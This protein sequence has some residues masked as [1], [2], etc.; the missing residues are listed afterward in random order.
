MSLTRGTQLGIY[1]VTAKS[2]EDGVGEVWRATTR[3]GAAARGTPSRRIGDD[4]PG[5]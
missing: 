5:S 1:E 3:G 2:G 4:Q